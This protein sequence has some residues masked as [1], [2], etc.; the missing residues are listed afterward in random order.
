MT[1]TM[2]PTA[3]EG[4][5]NDG[6]VLAR[7]V[8]VSDGDGCTAAATPFDALYATYRPLLR[9]IA[10]RKFGI[11]ADDVDDL[12]Q[13]VFATYLANSANVHDRHAYLI[14]ATCNAARQY[15][16]RDHTSPFCGASAECA[17]TPAD[18]VLEGVIRNL[19][20][21]ATLRRLGGSCRETLERFYLRG[22]T[23]AAIA[24]SRET[25]ANYIC[26]L[27]NYCRNRARSLYHEMSARP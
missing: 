22:E 3:T 8:L 7:T 14:G 10:I 4:N 18:E 2:T 6:S 5:A 9:K 15:L 16:R 12:V 24:E 26:R 17:A 11:P 19:I 1:R 27:L 20:L 13:D 25:S 21:G 23:T